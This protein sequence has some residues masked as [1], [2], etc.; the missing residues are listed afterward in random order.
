MVEVVSGIIVRHGRI[1]LQQRPP[2]KDFGFCWESA[3]GK[4]DGNESHHAALRRELLEELDIDIGEL[5][6]GQKPAW[7]GVF[8]NKV[9]RSDRAT[10]VLHFYTIGDRFSGEPSLK[11]GQP[12]MGWFSIDEMLVLNLAPANARAKSEITAQI[13]REVAR[14]LAHL[15]RLRPP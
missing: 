9:M 10:V 7:S 15:D 4:I 12:G 6:A 5:P 14:E 11:D 2:L 13:R 3:G 1:L 8:E